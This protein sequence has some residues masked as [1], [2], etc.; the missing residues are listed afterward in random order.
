MIAATTFFRKPDSS[1]T[2]SGIQNEPTAIPDGPLAH[3]NPGIL[4]VRS[5]IGGVLMGLANLV[6]GISGGT[7][8]LATGVYPKFIDAIANVTRL[9][10]RFESI[11]VLACVGGAAGAGIL[12]C[13]GVLKDL[14]INHRWVMYS[15]FIGLTLGGL[16]VVWRMARPASKSLVVSAIAA[17]AAMVAL[18]MLQAAGV[19]GS[20]GSNGLTLFCAG[21]AG[22]AAMILPGVSGGYLLLLMGQYIPILSG[23]DQFKSALRDRDISAMMDPVF[24]VI[25]PVG[26]GVVLG[27]ALVGNALQWLLKHRR[28]STLGGLIGLLLGSTVGLWPF[29]SPVAPEVGDTIK[30]QVVTEATISEIDPEDYATT[31]FHPDLKQVACSI[32]LVAAGFVLTMGIARI[33][34]DPSPEESGGTA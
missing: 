16:P 27:I 32:G 8:L 17:F 13:A 2:D 22:A 25:L 19:T 24:L 5:M 34:H 18:A 29:Q 30:G 23:I 6:P 7:M 26:L 15:L 10:F 9:R 33:G 14:V 31:Y 1:V 4:T 12:L 11:L 28:K 20:N 21:L 3:M